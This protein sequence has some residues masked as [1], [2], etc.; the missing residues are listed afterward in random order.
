MDN[1]LSGKA[2]TRKERRQLSARLRDEARNGTIS[3]KGRNVARQM[4]ID[5]E[6]IEAGIKNQAQSR[7]STITNYS[8]NSSI[9]AECN[10]RATE[11]NSMRGY[12]QSRN[13]TTVVM[14][15]IDNQ[16]SNEVYLVATNESDIGIPKTVQGLLKSDE[17]YI[18][19]KGHAEETIMNNK[20][21]RYTII[22]GGTSRNIC[23]GICQP[24]L[25]ADGLT[26]GGP[27]YRGRNDKTPYRQ[28]WR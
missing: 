10:R 15:A 22:A 1:V 7:Q 21:N 28:F 13:G 2:L 14:K 20:G 23:K 25:E 11:I 24:L 6:G 27:T 8:N 12:W 16:T 3:D 17:I 19:G 18:G 4:G 9:A 5:I 26:L